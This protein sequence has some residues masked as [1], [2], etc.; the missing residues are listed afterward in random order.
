MGG[1]KVTHPQSG[2]PS[3]EELLPRYARG[4]TIDDTRLV[5]VHLLLFDTSYGA[6]SADDARKWSEHFDLGG[7]HNIVVL[8]GDERFLGPE[9]FKMI[10]GFF[11]VDQNFVLRA[12]STGHYPRDDLFHDLLPMIPTLL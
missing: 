4:T 10:P 3:I 2:L 1:Y 5:L 11:L 8:A 12:D 7:R 6:P 9:S